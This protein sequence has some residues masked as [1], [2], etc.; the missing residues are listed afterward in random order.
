MNVTSA[1]AQPPVYSPISFRSLASG[2]L[3][4]F[5]FGD[6]QSGVRRLIAEEYDPRAVVLTDSGTTALA[7]AM[8][9]AMRLSGSGCVAIPNY[10]CFDIGTAAKASNCEVA[11][12]D[13]QPETLGP[14]FA[15]LKAALESGART[16]VVAHL[17]GIPVD[18]DRCRALCSEYDAVLVEDAAQGVGGEWNHRPLGSIGDL[19]VLSFGRGKGRTGGSGGALLANDSTG[20]AA[21]ELIQDVP[22]DGGRGLVGLIKLAGQLILGRPPLFRLA[23]AIPLLKLGE[24]IYR[25]PWIPR[26][27][28]SG[29]AAALEANWAI[30]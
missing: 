5:G 22:A 15:S 11:L 17:F 8:R 9:G 2:L 23:A 21:L 3:G 16:V 27:M 30:S 7:L 28:A 24:T 4:A 20:T 18:L 10:G 19:G 6:P 29:S 12:Y 1:K 14:H 25:E 13:I 26:G